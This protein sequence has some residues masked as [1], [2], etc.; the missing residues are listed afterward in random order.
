[1]INVKFEVIK[2]D[3]QVSVIKDFLSNRNETSNLIANFFDIDTNLDKNERNS[4]IENK[5]TRIYN[6][7]LDD[8]NISCL[9]F[10]Q[11]WNNNS[12]FINNELLKIFKKEFDLECVAYVN[13]NPVWPRY[14]DEKCFD[15]NLDASH[16]YLLS[17]SVHEIIHFIWFEIWKEN[18]PLIDRKDYDYPNLS[19]LI[20]EIAIEPIF[21]FS[22]LKDI[23]NTNNPAYDYFYTDKI[24]NKTIAVIANTIFEQSKDINDFQYK[25]YSFFK[26]NKEARKLIK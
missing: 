13:L 22:K 26:N 3:E 9:K 23:S 1:M 18:F 17:T 11:I 7:R 16:D 8:L 19:W 14:L 4:Q 21:R 12:Q 25:I 10:Q 24:E 6:E 20:S 15:V 2:L 5:I